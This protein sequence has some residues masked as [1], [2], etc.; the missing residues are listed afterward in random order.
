MISAI[1][2]VTKMS[3]KERVIGALHVSLEL[4]LTV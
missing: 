2:K 4:D 1:K 3:K